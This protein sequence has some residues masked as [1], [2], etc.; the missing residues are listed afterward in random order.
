MRSVSGEIA[1][2]FTF[3]FF[4]F[5][6]R[7]VWNRH[8]H[9]LDIM[10]HF[11]TFYMYTVNSYLPK[12]Y[13]NPLFVDWTENARAIKWHFSILYP[14]S[15]WIFRKVIGKIRH[16]IDSIPLQTISF[17]NGISFQQFHS[18]SLS[19]THTARFIVLWFQLN[20]ILIQI[21]FYCIRFKES[22]LFHHFH[23]PF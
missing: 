4:T 7:F 15:G 19:H 16:A 18:V 8:S 5:S 23:K 12:E 14:F 20:W 21:S 6:G 13:W 9:L 1:N 10:R 2:I 11:H 3:F 22:L 17:F